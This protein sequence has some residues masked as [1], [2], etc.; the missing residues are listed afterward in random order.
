MKTNEL[1]VKSVPD[2][3]NELISLQKDL[4]S[5][6][7]KKHLKGDDQIKQTHT[8]RDTRRKIARVKTILNER[9]REEHEQNR[10][11]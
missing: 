2:L 8:F 7:L 6:N 1:R 11:S 4:F 10:N 9:A 3:Q 5:L